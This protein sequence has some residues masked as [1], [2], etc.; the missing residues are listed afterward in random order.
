MKIDK[1]I[2][3][4]INVLRNPSLDTQIYYK[5]LLDFNK[6]LLFKRG[7]VIFREGSTIENVY[8]IKRGAVLL[9][10]SQIVNLNKTGM[11]ENS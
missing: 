5:F 6:Q 9:T 4:Y 3:F 1:K 7:N 11:E 8:I 2:K 10:K